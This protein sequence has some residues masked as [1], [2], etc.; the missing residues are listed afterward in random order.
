LFSGLQDGGVLFG[1][2]A[3]PPRPA[4]RRFVFCGL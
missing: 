1:E 4:F 2:E 3:A